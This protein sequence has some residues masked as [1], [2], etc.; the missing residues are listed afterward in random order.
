[1][2]EMHMQ[3]WLGHPPCYHEAVQRLWGCREEEG[4]GMDR[5]E[6]YV[7]MGASWAGMQKG[8]EDG[9]GGSVVTIVIPVSGSVR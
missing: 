7:G 2:A 6:G 5:R 9:R 3:G 8:C 4:L 1:M